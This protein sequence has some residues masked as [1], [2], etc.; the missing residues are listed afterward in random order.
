MASY[1]EALELILT[2]TLVMD[3]EEKPVSQSVGQVLADDTYANYDLPQSDSAGPDGYAV[4][5]ADIQTASNDYPAALRITETVRAGHLP[6]SPV[7]SG[8][9]M[10]IMTGAVLPDGAD[11]VVRF[12]DT[13]EP[14]DKNGPNKN[15][16]AEVRIYVSVPPGGNINKAGG[17]IARGSLILSRGKE[18]GPAQVSALTS[19][20]CATIKVTRRP[21]IAVLSTGD[22]LV[23]SGGPLP[24]GKVYDCNGPAIAALVEHYGGKVVMLGIAQD[25]E[26]S[27]QAKIKEGLQADALILSG[28]VSKGDYDLVRLTIAKLGELKFARVKM[29]PGASVSFGTIIKHPNTSKAISIPVFAL[30][31]PPTGCLINFETLVRPAIIKMLGH[32]VLDHP[33]V[34]AMAQEAI[35]AKRVMFAKWTE[36]KKV[37]GEYRIKLSNISMATAN[38]LTLIPEDYEVQP[39]T[40]MSVLPLDWCR[41]SQGNF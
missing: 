40:A 27:L 22:E 21:V 38:S 25:D 6:K 1:K 4:Q 28:G 11:C 37:G 9:A 16:P 10:R 18:I 39:G 41:N 5:A 17:N 34:T 23:N 30:A 29:V 8:T 20:G 13:D 14:P 33:T 19:V 12:E 31:G 24:P 7:K 32:T 35:P 2:N 36:L 3:T 26:E 15:N